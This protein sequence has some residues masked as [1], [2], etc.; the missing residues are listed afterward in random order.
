MI[1]C[2]CHVVSDRTIRARIS[3][4]ARTVDALGDACGAGTGC[5]GC[6]GQLAQMLVE[7]RQGPCPRAAHREDCA[8]VALPL[9]SAAL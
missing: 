5:G 8:V 6:K 4:G 3:E 2:L 1:V 9:V 7:A